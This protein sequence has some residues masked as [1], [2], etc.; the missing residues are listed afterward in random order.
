MSCTEWMVE[1]SLA[2]AAG[3]PVVEDAPS[4]TTTTIAA[5]MALC[6][7]RGL[8]GSDTPSNIRAARSRY[9]KQLVAA[10]AIVVDG[11]MVRLKG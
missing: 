10:G 2:V 1:G 7:S 4:G 5:W 3:V 6:V 11:E 8:I 9:V